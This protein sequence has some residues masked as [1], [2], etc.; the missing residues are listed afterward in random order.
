MEKIA[1]EA[2]NEFMIKYDDTH[3]KDISLDF[4]NFIKTMEATNLIHEENG[5]KIADAKNFY[6]LMIKYII[7][8]LQR[9][10]KP[11]IQ[12]IYLII[13]IKIQYYFYLYKL[14]ILSKRGILPYSPVEQQFTF[15]NSTFIFTLLLYCTYE[16][17]IS[18]LPEDTYR[19][20]YAALAPL[21]QQ[22]FDFFYTHQDKRY[23]L[24]LSI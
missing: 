11:L 13:N 6:I 9:I 12:D 10:Q 23:L 3:M 18:K 19:Q 4:G 21:L 7:N 2:I 20:I 16:N 24:S 22:L 5:E 15:Y 14:Y 8:F 17:Y 1:R